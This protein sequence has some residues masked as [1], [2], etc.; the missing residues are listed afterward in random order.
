MGVGRSGAAAGFVRRQENHGERV[1]LALVEC[2]YAETRESSAHMNARTAAQA[3]I[4]AAPRRLVLTHF[5]PEADASDVAGA[6]R[7]AGYAGPLTLASDGLRLAVGGSA[8]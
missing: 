1:D 4:E 8:A 2:S 6:V 7:R 3:A 5:Y